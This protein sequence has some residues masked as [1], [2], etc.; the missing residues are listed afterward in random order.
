MACLWQ[1]IFA[2]ET[3]YNICGAF[4][5]CQSEEAALAYVE[6]V[7][8]EEVVPITNRANRLARYVMFLISSWV[9]LGVKLRQK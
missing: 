3:T 2:K 9:S 1:K 6:G 5:Q 7:I 8:A 4:S